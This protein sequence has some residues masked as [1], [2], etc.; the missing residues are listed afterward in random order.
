[1]KVGLIVDYLGG[2]NWENFYCSN[3]QFFKLSDNTPYYRDDGFRNIFNIVVPFD[4]VFINWEYGLPDIKLDVLFVVIES[5]AADKTVRKL[6]EKYPH[7]LMVAYTK[8]K[9]PIYHLPKERLNLFTS[10]DKIACPY[11]EETRTFIEKKT[12]K[13]VYSMPYPY[14]IEMI[15][16]KYYKETKSNTIMC[17]CNPTNN[18]GYNESLNFSL[19]I[20][21][22]YDMDLIESPDY[23]WDKWLDILGS[24]KICVNMEKK[25]EIGQVA[26][27]CAILGVLHLGGISDAAKELWTSTSCNNIE[28]LESILN[29]DYSFVV[30]EAYAKVKERHSLETAINNLNII[31]ND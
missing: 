28:S 8:E 24:T 1:M 31:V 16:N 21:S 3:K 13:K 17:G 30:K 27:E 26:I 10:C 5:F 23:S 22:K 29:N 15:R 18:R 2:G 11:R 19:Q 25:L 12:G 6:R 14:D 9:N 7:T 20:K 4:G